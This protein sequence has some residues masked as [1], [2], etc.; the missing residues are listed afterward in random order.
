MVSWFQIKRFLRFQPP[1]SYIPDRD[2]NYQS[3]SQL[4]QR[5]DIKSTINLFP[6]PPQNKPTIIPPS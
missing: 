2:R 4:I 1:F 5:T 6:T 3:L